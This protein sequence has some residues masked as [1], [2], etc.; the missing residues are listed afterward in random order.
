MEEAHVRF[1]G[2]GAFVFVVLSKE[3]IGTRK[4]EN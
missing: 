3:F 2:N 1:G 4:V